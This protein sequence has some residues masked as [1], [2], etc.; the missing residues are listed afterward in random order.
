M[1]LIFIIT[2]LTL[3]CGS[4]CIECKP[5]FLLLLLHSFKWADGTVIHLLE[6]VDRSYE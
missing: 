3:S 6:E 4:A 1:L 2:G 5:Q